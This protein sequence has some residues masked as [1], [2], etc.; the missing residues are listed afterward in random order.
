M[1]VVALPRPFSTERIVTNVLEGNTLKELMDIAGI[2]DPVLASHCRVFIDDML[3][4]PKNFHRVRPK[5]GTQISIRV[6]PH[7]GGGKSP[8]R[9]VLTLVVMV[10]AAY[11]APIIVGAA[12]GLSATA[13]AA[14]YPL[15]TV[16]TRGVLTMVGNLVVNSLIPPS[17]PSS[18]SARTSRVGSLGGGAAGASGTPDA[19]LSPTLSL[20][21]SRN[22]QA[23]FAVIPRVYGQYK[24]YPPHAAKP[25]T[26]VSGDD[27][28]LRMLFCFGYG[29]VSI[30]D[31]KIGNTALDDYEG[32]TYNFFD[33]S[34]TPSLSIYTNDV[35][36][37]DYT[38]AVT[39]AGGAQTITTEPLT[40]EVSLDLSFSG[41][42]E[43][44]NQNKRNTRSVVVKV[45]YRPTSG[46]SWTTVTGGNI[47]I[48]AK[49]DQ[50]YRHPV[51]FA[52]GSADEY[53]VKVTRVTADSSDITIRDSIIL[54]AVRSIKYISPVAETGVALLEM[55]IRATDQLNG[56]VDEFSAVTQ[57]LLPIWTGSA[58][59]AATATRNPA[60]AY[61]DVLRGS[62]NKRPLADARIDTT[63]L[64]AWAT[65]CDAL[66]QDGTAYW[67]F[68]GI[69]DYSTTV[70]EMLRTI[71]ASGRAAFGMVDSKFSVVRDVLQTTP[72]QNFS[73]R[74]SSGFKGTRLFTSIP[75]ALKVRHIDPDSN[76]EQREQIVYADG[77]T[78]ANATEFE[79]LELFGCTRSG[80]AWREGRY[81]LGVG[82]LRPDSY[83]LQTDIENLVCTRGDLVRVQHDVPRWGLQTV[84]I[85]TVTTDGN[86]DVSDLTLDDYV[87]MAGGTVYS[88]R[89]RL[90][91]FTNI[92]ATPDTVAGDT[93]ALTFTVTIPSDS[94]PAVGDLLQFG[95]AS[96]ESVELVLKDIIPGPDLTAQLIL[97]DA[98]PGVHTADTGTIP[99]YTPQST[100]D[101]EITPPSP[102]VNLLGTEEAD[103][104]SGK[105][106]YRLVL[107]W[108][109]PVGYFGSAYEVYLHD[110][111]R[112]VL[113]NIVSSTS[114]TFT[115]V[116]RGDAIKA[117]VIAVSPKGNK[118][119]IS[120]APNI[121]HTMV[122]VL[123]P[124]V[125]GLSATVRGDTIRLEWDN[126]VMV[127]HW[128]VRWSPDIAGVT[129]G[130]GVDM[131]TSA[132]SPVYEGPARVGTYMVKSVDTDS[133][134]ATA[135]T[136]VVTTAAGLNALNV[137]ETQ[138][139]HPTFAGTHTNTV[140]DGT[141]LQ[142]GT[143]GLFDDGVG[144][145]DD[146][147]GLFDAGG[148][149][150]SPTGTYGFANYIDLT[151]VYSSRVTASIKSIGVDMLNLFDDGVGFF[152][153]GVG[154]FDGEL[155][156][157]VDV[158][159]QIA[160]TDD[161]PSGS[162]TWS[163]WS[164]FVVGDYNAR[165][166]KFQAILTSDHGFMTPS[167]SELTVTVDMPDRTASDDDIL[168]SAS[169]EAVLFSPAFRVKP[170]I[171][172]TG[173]DMATGDYFTVTSKSATGFTV[174]FYNSSD[175]GIART[176]D[177]LAKG[178][179]AVV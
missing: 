28:Y 83:E 8:A 11:L 123:P 106:D 21:G 131:S 142:L 137:V 150:I 126:A 85:K 155:P 41:L 27:Q 22:S 58:W 101:P 158:V 72:I 132:R 84:R 117:A 4:E 13:A 61:A 52:T 5:A 75:H 104:V 53:D 42:V 65:A 70:F 157:Q 168:A 92:T 56:I 175:V 3:I 67:T 6:V 12:T 149:T 55:R 152:D 1:R 64:L 80:Q 103:I 35:N 30:S 136:S 81:N 128:R 139:E 59:S 177:W 90:N 23:P 33:G 111:N 144:N 57:A 110:G 161:D 173:E 74:N 163:G 18:I 29:P 146:G 107:T 114:Y 109:A 108:Q 176:F 51:V 151:Q 31:L 165:A 71:A 9:L 169:G 148:G 47:T 40:E 34:S 14:A 102:V 49:T 113:Q 115:N 171:A 63:G 15:A 87:T 153:D 174:T 93:N 97:I 135:E 48:S 73:P 77:Y 76:W 141:V 79:S 44:D 60:W 159:L 130:S 39:V 178:Y 124:T 36:Q 99:T 172:I 138:N 162:P 121:N 166:F 91:D 167:V 143:T 147:V 100:D 66:A 32:V 62:A 145:F 10:A 119:S 116:N 2:S 127:D 46:G 20:T 98:A 125:T 78:V 19:R 96:S 170:A 94:V 140:T 69:V 38:I 105:Y 82:T 26:E 89:I 16:L 17:Q 37:S 112:Y 164:N 179:G 24:M 50:V 122:G 88:V 95:E 7:G 25:Y 156:G 118:L 133:Y 54:T 68:D 120:E 129:W 43:F 154:L 160:T 45:E 86:G 134:E